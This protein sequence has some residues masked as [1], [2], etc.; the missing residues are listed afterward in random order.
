MYYRRG[1]GFGGASPPWPYVGCGR[2]G[3]P[4]CWYPGLGANFPSR[5][6]PAAYSSEVSPEQ[7]LNFLKEEGTIIKKHLNDVETRVKELEGKEK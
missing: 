4:R 1:L 6:N 7:E 2:G 5:F 3:F